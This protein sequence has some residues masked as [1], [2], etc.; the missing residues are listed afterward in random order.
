MKIKYNLPI[1]LA[2]DFNA[3]T[4]IKKDFSEQYNFLADLFGSENL[5]ENGSMNF[6]LLNGGFTAYSY[7]QDT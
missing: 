6:S 2:G 7:N 5:S 1:C 4:G 3:Y